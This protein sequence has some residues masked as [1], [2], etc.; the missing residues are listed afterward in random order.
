MST[1]PPTL[2]VKTSWHSRNSVRSGTR[3]KLR[4][5]MLVIKESTALPLIGVIRQVKADGR[6]GVTWFDPALGTQALLPGGTAEVPHFNETLG[7][8]EVAALVG[9]V[10]QLR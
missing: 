7:A 6:I 5:G 8:H 9:Q 4:S 2:E 10:K 3:V 1:P